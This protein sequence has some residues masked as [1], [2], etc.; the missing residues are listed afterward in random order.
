MARTT[1]PPALTIGELEAN[2]PL[3][4]RALRIL[5]R[6]GSSLANVRRTVC[7]SRLAILH[8]TLP[9][10]YRDPEHLYFLLSREIDAVHPPSASS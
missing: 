9:R 4:C 2:Y 5:I 6:E 10:N 8:H 7:W 3:Y 1:S